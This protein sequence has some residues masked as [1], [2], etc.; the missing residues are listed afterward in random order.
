MKLI[1]LQINA[2]R[3]I[4]LALCSMAILGLASCK[5]EE[6]K[7]TTTV[8]YEV[9]CTNCT[10]SYTNEYGFS[11]TTDVVGNWKATLSNYGVEMAR[12]EV[13]EK[14][15]SNIHVQLLL[16]DYE[17]INKFGPGKYEYKVK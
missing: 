15:P 16:N 2:M 6:I 8:G 12:I 3:K 1:S 5:K 11:K 17:V 13:T 9:T 7:P 10:V 14:Q 4:T